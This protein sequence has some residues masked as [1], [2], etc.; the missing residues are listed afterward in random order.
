MQGRLAVHRGQQ[1]LHDDGVEAF[2]TAYADS[3]LNHG[4]C[5]VVRDTDDAI[6]FAAYLM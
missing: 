6:M 1:H 2:T 3:S 4:L 5:A